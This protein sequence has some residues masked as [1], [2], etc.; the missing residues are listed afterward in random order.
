M[1][2]RFGEYGEK[3]NQ[4]GGKVIDFI[5]NMTYDADKVKNFLEDNMIYIIMGLG[6]LIA[7]YIYFMYIFRRV[8][9]A[10]R[11]TRQYPK[12]MMLTPISE[13]KQIMEGRF[14]LC[15]F[16]VASSYRSYLPYQ[17]FI[18]YAE[19]KA[20]QIA[21]EAGARYIELDIWHRGF[22]YDSPP[23]VYQGREAG[24]WAWTNRL[25][26]EK[27]IQLITE[28]AFGSDKVP[29]GTDPLFIYLNIHCDSNYKLLDKIANILLKYLDHK[30]YKF[31]PS[32]EAP[33]PGMAFI[34]DFIGKVV[35][36]SNKSWKLSPMDN[37]VNFVIGE[38]IMSL[39]HGQV[40]F[41]YDPE[42]MRE[43]NRKGLTRVM[44]G[45]KGRETTNYNPMQ[46]WLLGC[47]FV[48]IN[49]QKSDIYMDFYID[50]FKNCS[51][52]LKPEALRYKPLRYFAAKPQTEAVSY[53]P[54]TA[55]TPYVSITY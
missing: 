27:C 41:P 3:F 43:I 30:L 48:C 49:Y 55:N 44:P 1:D 10:L 51:F 54:R 17:Q 15:D 36:I 32:E 26:F 40:Q 33:T 28:V 18:D 46:A 45:F 34:K 23:M 42:H 7:L 50:K 5:K 16:Y 4:Y 24:N 29:N 12:I 19:Y 37:L 9:Y 6:G 22:C 13:N 11:K 25:T 2:S 52:V 8:H 31:V 39:E 35:I 21:L 38:S 47:Q 20:I 14:R 53:A